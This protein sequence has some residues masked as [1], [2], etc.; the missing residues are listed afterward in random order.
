VA[1]GDLKQNLTVASK[2]EVAALA[3]T[4][5]NM[6]DTLATFADQVTTVAA[7]WAWK[8]ARRSG[9]RAGAAGTW[10]DLTG[11]VNLLAANLTTQ[12]RAIAEV[13]PR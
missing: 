13:P 5:N 1:D 8:A 3:E 12:V 4:I 2:G 9:Q 7:K 10:K 11:N 6:T